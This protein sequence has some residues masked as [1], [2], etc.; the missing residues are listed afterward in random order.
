[1]VSRGGGG[2]GGAKGGGVVGTVWLRGRVALCATLAMLAWMGPWR[3]SL[4]ASRA[5]TVALGASIALGCWA[6]LSA[7]WS[8]APDIAIADGQRILAD[9]VAFGLGHW[10]SALVGGRRPLPLLPLAVAGAFA[11][12]IAAVGMHRGRHL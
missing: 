5:V 7:I 9:A 2:W 4:G 8:P 6:A 1:A 3:G 11:G 12:A 10:L